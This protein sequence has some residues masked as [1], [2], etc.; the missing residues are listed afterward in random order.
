MVDFGPAGRCELMDELKI[1]MMKVPRYLSEVGLTAFEYPLT[2]GVNLP[3]ETA[4]KI[5]DEFKKYNIKLS[6]H[7]PFYINLANVSDEMAEKSFAY[8]ISSLKIMDAMGADR[9][10]FHPGA[11]MGQTRAQA[12]SLILKR[13]KQLIPILNDLN[14]LDGKYLC[15]ETMG[16]H[17]QCGTVSEVAD[18]CKIDPHIM[19]TID[20]G[21]INAFTLGKLDSVDAFCDIFSELE[22]VLGERAKTIHG[23]FS[24]IEYGEKGELKHLNFNSPEQFGPNYKLLNKALKKCNIDARIMCESSGNQTIDSLEMKKDYESC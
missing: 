5:G 23:H 7:G 2:R 4:K 22:D 6:V 8:I 12:Q 21:H 14:L 24:R 15:P 13:L 3:L 16:K 1:D 11:L 9:L 10:V 19:P 20:F 17:G 18:M